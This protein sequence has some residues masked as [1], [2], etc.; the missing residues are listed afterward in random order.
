[1]LSAQYVLYKNRTRTEEHRG[2]GGKEEQGEK[3]GEETNFHKLI[4]NPFL[5]RPTDMKHE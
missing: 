3:A 2:E 1:M 5:S 4:A